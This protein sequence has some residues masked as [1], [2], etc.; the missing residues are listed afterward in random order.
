MIRI[1]YKQVK[2]GFIFILSFIIIELSLNSNKLSNMFISIHY[3]T[4]HYI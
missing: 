3:E 2:I 1:Y 4:I